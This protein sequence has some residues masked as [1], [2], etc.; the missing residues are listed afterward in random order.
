M[1]KKLFMPWKWKKKKKSFGPQSKRSLAD[2]ILMTLNLA[3]YSMGQLAL[4][5][6]TCSYLDLGPST[7]PVTQIMEA[8][9][10]TCCFLSRSS[11]ASYLLGLFKQ[12]RS[13]QKTSPRCEAD[14]WRCRNRLPQVCAE[15]SIRNVRGNVWTQFSRECD[16]PGGDPGHFPPAAH[17]HD[18]LHLHCQL[19]T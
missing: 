8:T 4:V 15:C 18:W 19:P 16:Q 3:S 7:L 12:I 13:S 10:W 9:A 14:L 17:H 1:L 11:L 5:T 6:K 2:V